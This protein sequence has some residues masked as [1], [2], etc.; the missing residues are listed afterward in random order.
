[1]T[2]TL[3][4]YVRSHGNIPELDGPAH[5]LVVDGQVAATSSLSVAA[6]E[7]EAVLQRAATAMPTC[8][9]CVRPPA[10]RGG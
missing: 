6:H 8:S 4:F 5:R 9:R 1:M 3:D 7:V 2:D 10:T